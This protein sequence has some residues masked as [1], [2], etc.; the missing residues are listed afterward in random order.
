[1]VGWNY[2]ER[3]LADLE[4]IYFD[5]IRARFSGDGKEYRLL[6]RPSKKESIFCNEEVWKLFRDFHFDAL[7]PITEAEKPVDDYRRENPGK[8]LDELLK[9]RDK[10]WEERVV[11]KIKENFGRSRRRIDDINVQNAPLVLLRRALDTLQTNDTEAEAFWNDDQVEGAVAELNTL[12]YEFK[13][14]IKESRRN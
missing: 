8:S 9:H 1:M 13:K 12:M 3:D 7:E 10:D 4:L 2:S 6:G 5:L 14:S 11:P